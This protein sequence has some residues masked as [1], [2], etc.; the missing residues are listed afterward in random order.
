M[1]SR[2]WLFLGEASKLQTQEFKLL[3]PHGQL[4]DGSLKKVGCLLNDK[5]AKKENV[6][7]YHT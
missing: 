6:T 4:K 7:R 5:R 1:T 3:E 2:P